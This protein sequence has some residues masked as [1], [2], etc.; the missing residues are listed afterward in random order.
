MVNS[1]ARATTVATHQFILT[2][3]FHPS[4]E[5]KIIH[6]PVNVVVAPQKSL[7]RISLRVNL[8]HIGTQHAFHWTVTNK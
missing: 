4:A 3:P 1:T 7:F 8:L 2:F 5:R 6:L